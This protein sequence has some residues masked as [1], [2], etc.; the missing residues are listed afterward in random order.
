M[1][2]SASSLRHLMQANTCK[3]YVNAYAE[4][5]LFNHRN[6]VLTQRVGSSEVLNSAVCRKLS[7]NLSIL[8]LIYF[9]LNFQNVMNI[10]KALT[11]LRWRRP[12][13]STLVQQFNCKVHLVILRQTYKLQQNKQFE[14]CN[15]LVTSASGCDN[16]V[17]HSNG[18]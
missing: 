9:Y 3:Q 5:L 7:I 18:K 14:I 17:S 4:F 6:H 10:I 1:Q 11:Y 2:Y 12:R 13:Y 15:V 8:G 16:L